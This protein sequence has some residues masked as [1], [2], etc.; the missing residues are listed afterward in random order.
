ML[1]VLEQGLCSTSCD[2]ATTS[3]KWSDDGYLLKSVAHKCTCCGESK[4]LPLHQSLDVSC[5]I[6]SQIIFQHMILTLNC[7]VPKK[8]LGSS[9]DQQDW[10][11]LMIH[12]QLVQMPCIRS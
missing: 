12:P 4:L 3:I 8:K 10:M 7:Q 5:T 6:F 1:A 9:L 11:C 2:S